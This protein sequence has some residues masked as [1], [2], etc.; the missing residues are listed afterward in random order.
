MGDI[1]STIAP[2][3][4]AQS[5]SLSVEVS[6]R[7]LARNTLL[8]FLGQ[9]LPTVVGVATIPITIRGLGPDRFG[10]L[11]IAWVVFGYFGV[12]DLGLGRATTKFVAEYLAEN[13]VDG[14]PGI[15][16]TSVLIQLAFGLVGTTIL[17]AF[18]PFLTSRLLKVPP[19]LIHE[20]TITLWLLGAALPV[21][22]AT[23]GLRA[24]LEGF[25]R[26]DLTN[27]LRV[28]SS[29]LTFLIP[30]VVLSFGLRLPGIALWLVISRLF[31]AVAHLVLYRRVMP[32][33]PK[34]VVFELETV[35]PLLFYGGWVTVANIVS[36]ILLYLDRFLI[37]FTLSV[38]LVG[39]YTA[40]FEVVLKLALIPASLA[41]TIFPACSALGLSRRRKLETLYSRSIKYL[42]LGLSPIILLGV[43]LAKKII[44]VWLGP[45]FA[46]RSSVVL[47]VL[48]LGVFVTCIASIP[49]GF[50]QALGHPDVVA[51]LLLLEL[52]VYAVIAWL[53]IRSYGL[54]G[55]ATAWSVRMV[56]ELF[57]LLLLTRKLFDLSPRLFGEAGLL[58]GLLIS[59]VLALVMVFNSLL[60]SDYLWAQVSSC[61]ICVLGFCVAVWRLA[62]DNVDRDSVLSVLTPVVKVIKGHTT[63]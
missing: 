32:S 62:F 35:K 61:A 6:P 8:N 45:D 53:T 50:L 9:C 4:E 5:A 63:A 59:L 60:L 30:A 14:I 20:T 36:P 39:Y 42:I 43:V 10:V 23:N 24:A 11:S 27:I 46:A 47:Q 44:F 16:W 40:P 7:R 41:T 48:L 51:K 56:V 31:F 52:P 1:S 58:R 17:F 25:H 26:F 21:V 12:F 15:V 2:Q 33:V 13:K 34:R 28:P 22:L 18:A 37:G 19:G 38:T 55:A 3:H 29:A 54:V 49:F 57:L